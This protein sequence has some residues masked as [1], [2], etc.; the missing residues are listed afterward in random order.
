M[1]DHFSTS[2]I[3]GGKHNFLHTCLS[4][5]AFNFRRSDFITVRLWSVCT[6]LSRPTPV[7]SYNS[8]TLIAST[9][10][11]TTG[12]CCYIL[13]YMGK[14]VIEIKRVFSDRGLFLLQD[15]VCLNIWLDTWDWISYPQETTTE[16][17][18]IPYRK[19]LKWDVQPNSVICPVDICRFFLAISPYFI[20]RDDFMT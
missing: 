4:V 14:K 2:T 7:C 11:E 5:V 17:V 1:Q 10:V 8:T 12:L 18:F 19:T 9:V 6:K 16:W 15:K 13:K 20:T 3:A